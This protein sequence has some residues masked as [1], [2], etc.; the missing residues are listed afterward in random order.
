MAETNKTQQ[1]LGVLSN[2]H[3]PPPPS[4]PQYLLVPSAWEVYGKNVLNHG[5]G[6]HRHAWCERSQQA[7]VLTRDENMKIN[8]P[9][10]RPIVFSSQNRTG[11]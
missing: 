9:I 4:W 1:G 8:R 7:Q 2:V 3:P 6:G 11:C 10:N 5:A